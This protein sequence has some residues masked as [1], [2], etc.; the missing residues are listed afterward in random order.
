MTLIGTVSLLPV[1]QLERKSSG[2]TC[3]RVRTEISLQKRFMWLDEMARQG[4]ALF[5][6]SDP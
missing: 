3:H 4:K 2:P 5:H 6:Q 1:R